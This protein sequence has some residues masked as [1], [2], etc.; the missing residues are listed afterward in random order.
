[1]DLNRFKGTAQE[2]DV[3]YGT[4]IAD[5]DEPPADPL[6]AFLSQ[7]DTNWHT[8]QAFE[9]VIS[10]GGGVITSLDSRVEFVIEAGMLVTDTTF[11]YTPQP[12][13]DYAT[14]LLSFA[15]SSFQLTAEDD[16]GS[17]ETFD[18]PIIATLYYSDADLR[19]VPEE[20]LALYYWDEAA[21]DWVDIVTTCPDG[22]YTRDLDGN[23]LSVPICH[24]SEFAMLGEPYRSLLPLVQVSR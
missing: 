23:V 12:D 2:F 4:H 16:D 8:L 1:M 19:S 17:V 24:L 9:Q 6:Q 11:T 5:P 10:S 18:P 15:G 14:G 20:S 13:A 7:K 3:R 21:N 22:E